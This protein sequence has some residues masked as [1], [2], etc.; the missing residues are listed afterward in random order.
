MA[1]S[2]CIDDLV[3]ADGIAQ[4]FIYQKGGVKKQ[5]VRGDYVQLIDF[6]AKPLALRFPLLIPVV[7]GLKV[8][9]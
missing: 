9:L 5:V 7:K 6:P 3:I 2:A 4:T 8:Y 1:V